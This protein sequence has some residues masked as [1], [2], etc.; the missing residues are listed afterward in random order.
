MNNVVTLHSSPSPQ[1]CVACGKAMAT[2]RYEPEQFPYLAGK[3]Q[4]MLEARVPV[5]QCADCGTS[6][7]SEEAEELRHEAVCRYLGRLTPSEVKAVREQYDLSQQE[8]AAKTGFGVASVKRWEAGNL[9]QERAADNYLRLLRNPDIFARVVSF[10]RPAEPRG[11][12]QFQTALSTRV[13]EQAAIFQL[14]K[15]LA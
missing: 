9:I 12:Y 14:R 3:D 1:E 8:W 11:G 4:V 6:F 5:W 7:T 15:R 10:V 13:F 2:L